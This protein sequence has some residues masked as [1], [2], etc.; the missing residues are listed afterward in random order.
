MSTEG[1][2]ALVRRTYN[3]INKRNLK[4]IDELVD[5]NYVGHIPAFPPV[6]GI[7]GLQ[8]VFSTYL[9]A[10]PDMMATIEDQSPRGIRLLPV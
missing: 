10:F 3:V 6:Q 1:N 9:T 5:L 8:Q 4:A 7:E 2:K